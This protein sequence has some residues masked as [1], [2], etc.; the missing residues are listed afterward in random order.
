MLLFS[1]CNLSLL[2]T[3]K[4]FCIYANFLIYFA[5]ASLL[6]VSLN[7][8]I[9][10]KERIKGQKNQLF[11]IWHLQTVLTFIHTLT[12]GRKN[13]YAFKLS[14]YLLQH[15]LK[16]TYTLSAFH[17]LRQGLSLLLSPLIC[18][19]LWECIFRLTSYMGY[20]P[21]LS[22]VIACH[23]KS[24]ILCLLKGIFFRSLLC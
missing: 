19:L 11:S 17:L 24:R 6:Y 2:F 8:K 5:S 7:L 14:L 9:W 21:S 1:Y 13:V 3:N 4:F 18:P 16:G 15:L 20:R 22:K 12:W 10:S 23:G